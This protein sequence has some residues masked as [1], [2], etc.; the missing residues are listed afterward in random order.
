MVETETEKLK[1]LDESFKKKFEHW[2][3]KLGPRKQVKP[4]DQPLTYIFSFKKYNKLFFR[5]LK[6]NFQSKC[7][8]GNNFL[9]NKICHRH[10]PDR[11]D[12]Q[13]F[14]GYHKIPRYLCYQGSTGGSDAVRGFLSATRVNATSQLPIV[15]QTLFL[16]LFHYTLIC[17]LHA[18][19]GMFT[20][21]YFNMSH[22]SYRMIHIT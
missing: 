2:R 10:H 9:V 11:K 22:D 3:D 16:G 15:H 1:S 5:S 20:E 21:P 18:D 19:F 14:I 7:W 6:S 13:T 12:S 4:C 8:N 17:T